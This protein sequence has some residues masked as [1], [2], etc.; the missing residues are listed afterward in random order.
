MD[1][2]FLQRQREEAQFAEEVVF[3]RLFF[4]Q[5]QLSGVEV[6]KLA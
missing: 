5:N 3:V 1:E 4:H 2:Y 6:T